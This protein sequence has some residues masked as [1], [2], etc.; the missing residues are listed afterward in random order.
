[1][2]LTT[3][4]KRVVASEISREDISTPVQSNDELAKS[5]EKSLP[6]E[7]EG[8]IIRTREGV[9]TP[10]ADGGKAAW[11]FLTGCFVFEALVW[12]K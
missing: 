6:K 9:D 4:E 3:I 11:L 10:R 5:Q 1:M 8:G 7:V 2:I 12:G